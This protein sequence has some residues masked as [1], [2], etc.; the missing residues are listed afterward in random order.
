MV[1]REKYH[2]TTVLVDWGRPTLPHHC[3]REGGLTGCAG[4]RTEGSGPG[5]RRAGP[6][7]GHLLSEVLSPAPHPP[8]PQYPEHYVICRLC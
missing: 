4:G 3:E 1:S 5:C 7:P 6:G 8:P 2:M